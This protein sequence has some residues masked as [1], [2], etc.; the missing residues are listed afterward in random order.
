MTLEVELQA[1]HDAA[2]A[3]A[4]GEGTVAAVMAA[5]PAGGYRVYVVALEC[6]GELSYLAL[7]A[8]LEPLRDRRLVR[9]AVTM[10]GLAER[11]EEASTAIVADELDA[12]FAE[13]E[14]ALRSAGQ[15][16]P[17]AAA[18]A[19]RA[20]LAALSEVVAGPRLATP[21]FL[22]RVG[23]AAAELGRCLDEY[24]FH[25][26]RLSDGAQAASPEAEAAWSALAL[27]T[28]TGHPSD[29]SQ[30]MTATTGAVEALA[31]DVLARLRSYD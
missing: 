19:V 7:D 24:R 22:D 30:A 1:A 5:E 31:D 13:A 23:G 21:L 25:A 26:E 12:P 3:L 20:A 16:A 28:R 8:S 17:A 9:E 29:F 10:L 18:A 27:A 11:A 4:G 15:E 6:G 14:R 2:G